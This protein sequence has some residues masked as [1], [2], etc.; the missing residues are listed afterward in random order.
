MQDDFFTKPHCS[1]SVSPSPTVLDCPGCR[2]EVEVW[3]D[4]DAAV[5]PSCGGEVRKPL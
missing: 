5:C 4:E 3:S 2:E 1:V